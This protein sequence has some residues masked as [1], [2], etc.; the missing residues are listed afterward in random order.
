MPAFKDDSGEQRSVPCAQGHIGAR[1]LALRPFRGLLEGE[2]L[3]A[4]TDH[5]FP[6]LVLSYQHP[7]AGRSTVTALPLQL[8]QPPLIYS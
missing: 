1:P 7:A 6:S 5:Q 2:P 4:I 8:Q 3:S